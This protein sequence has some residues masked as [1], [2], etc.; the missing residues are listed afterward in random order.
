MN[1][2]SVPVALVRVQAQPGHGDKQIHDPTG[3][4]PGWGLGTGVS[5]QL[6]GSKPS[7][8][9]QEMGPPNLPSPGTLQGLFSQLC[10]PSQPTRVLRGSEVAGVPWQGGKSQ[11]KPARKE[12]KNNPS[13]QSKENK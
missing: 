4:Q 10:L 8:M 9:S 2:I 5:A 11:P 13:A 3:S 7:W 6:W 12:K 1:R